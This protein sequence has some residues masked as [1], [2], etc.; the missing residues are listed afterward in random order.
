MSQQF[1]DEM[2]NAEAAV[3]KGLDTLTARHAE[4]ETAFHEAGKV[5]AEIKA[6]RKAALVSG[7]EKA[8]G[9]LRKQ[10]TEVEAQQREQAELMQALADA[11][12]RAK[13]E[14]Q[15]AH[16]E[17][18]K[19][20]RDRARE[21]LADEIKRYKTLLPTLIDCMKNMLTYRRDASEGFQRYDILVSTLP[22]YLYD[23]LDESPRRNVILWNR[24]TVIE[25]IT[26]GE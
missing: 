6:Q 7:D 25:N 1:V 18:R 11:I 17:T 13:T 3:K 2:A 26:K 10:E 20:R 19:A 23:Y 15:Q 12:D 8:V 4:A 16:E 22:E 14:L 21:Q 5:H 9:K 24:G